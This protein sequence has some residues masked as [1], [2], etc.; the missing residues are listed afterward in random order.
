MKAVILWLC[1]Y[2]FALGVTPAF[3]QVIKLGTV[4]PEGSPWH[5]TLL[6]VAQQWKDLSNG[7]VTVRIYA[8]GVAGD[9]KDMLRKIRIGQLHAT[10]LTSVTLIDIIPDIEALTFPLFIR[11]DE[12]LDYVMDKLGPEF[13]A[14]LAKKGFKVLTWSTTGWAHFFTKEP[15]IG[16]EDMKKRKLFFWGSDTTYM[17]LLKDS[18]FN[19]VGLAI[20]DLLPSLQTGLIDSFAA[21]PAAALSFQWF[22]LAPHMTDLRWQ[23]LPGTTVVSMK[24]WNSI[25]ADLRPM[26]EEAARKAGAKL[27]KRIRELEQ[28]AITAMKKHGLTV[29]AVPVQAQ[30]EWEALVRE[31]AYP[32]FVGPRFSKAMYD[33]VRGILDECRSPSRQCPPK[34]Y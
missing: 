27:Q 13:E 14:R 21:P 16:P 4:A 22:A 26:L 5:D 18:G 9:E 23:P 32:V 20:T 28:E 11:T 33:N 19:P 12:E 30:Q 2:M 25:P 34:K 31:K 1:I 8:G 24:K 29:H 10:A 15:V 3:S 17:E 7:S 6:E